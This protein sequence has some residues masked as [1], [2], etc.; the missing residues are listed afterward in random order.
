MLATLYDL[1]PVLAPRT[2]IH[3][4]IGIEGARRAQIALKHLAGGAAAFAIARCTED[5]DTGQGDFRLAALANSLHYHQTL[6]PSNP[7]SSAL[8]ARSLSQ[9]LARYRSSD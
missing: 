1:H 8:A 6:L 4:T 5:R 7:P 3:P 2:V 9:N